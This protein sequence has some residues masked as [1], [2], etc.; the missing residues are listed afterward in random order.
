MKKIDNNSVIKK[1]ISLTLH[2]IL[3]NKIPIK[4]GLCSYWDDMLMKDN[5][6]SVLE[7]QWMLEYLHK[8]PTKTVIKASKKGIIDIRIFYFWKEGDQRW[9]IYWL[10]KHLKIVS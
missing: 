7:H 8:H 4:T 1:I 3:E 2:N 5:T 10:Q 6:I 9:R